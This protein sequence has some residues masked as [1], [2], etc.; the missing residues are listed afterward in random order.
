MSDFKS[1]QSQQSQQ[2]PLYAADAKKADAPVSGGAISTESVKKV[3]IAFGI[4]AAII[5]FYYMF[6]KLSGSG[7][8]MEEKFKAFRKIQENILRTIRKKTPPGG[9]TL[10]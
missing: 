9:P 10:T 5:L 2:S 6:S 8:S 7:F 4:I 3:A 1:Q